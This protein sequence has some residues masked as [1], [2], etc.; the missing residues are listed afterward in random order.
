MNNF[1]LLTV[2]C[3]LAMV[4][5]FSF[6]HPTTS[7]SK[8]GIGAC[9]RSAHSIRQYQYR[10]TFMAS[11]EKKSSEGNT[12]Q[13]PKI[14]WPTF[15]K[16]GS[17]TPPAQE[18]SRSSSDGNEEEVDALVVG[19]G[20]SGSTCAYYLDK[21]GVNVMMCEARDVIGGNLISKTN[22][23]GTYKYMCEEV[24]IHTSFLSR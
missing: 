3:I 10:V 11:T 6:H 22:D 21:Q 5:S 15:G 18:V 16:D 17:S 23:E 14:N 24:I 7:V 4:V 12:W 2:A 9:F 1:Y 13:L 19:S 20:I 8:V